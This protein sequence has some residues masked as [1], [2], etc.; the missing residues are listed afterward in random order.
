MR[1]WA[2][3]IGQ[4]MF[5]GRTTKSPQAAPVFQYQP[6]AAGTDALSSVNVE[7]W[8]EQKAQELNGEWRL[9]RVGGFSRGDDVDTRQRAGAM[10]RP[11]EEVFLESVLDELSSEPIINVRTIGGVVVGHLESSVATTVARQMIEGELVRSFVYSVTLT[12]TRVPSRILLAVMFWR[13]VPTCSE[14]P[15]EDAASSLP[16]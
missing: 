2:K 5:R 1:G 10:L 6:A 9:A 14:S 8:L 13:F 11:T 7:H 12:E 3:G 16:A 4:R 15:V